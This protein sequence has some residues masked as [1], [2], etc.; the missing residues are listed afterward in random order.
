MSEE[1]TEAECFEI[2][3]ER[4]KGINAK[5]IYNKIIPIFVTFAGEEPPVSMSKKYIERDYL[6]VSIVMV[7]FIHCMTYGI[8]FPT[9]KDN[10]KEF[11]KIKVKNK[12]LWHLIK[13]K[14]EMYGK[15]ILEENGL[16]LIDKVGEN[17]V[18]VDKNTYN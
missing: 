9:F 6:E 11:D 17:Y 15:E 5:D 2:L 1:R 18:V 16:E 14:A 3:Y 10:D 7:E 13:L 12:A 4:I 8:D